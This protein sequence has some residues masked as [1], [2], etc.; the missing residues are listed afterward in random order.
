MVILK[1]IQFYV[2]FGHFKNIQFYVTLYR[3]NLLPLLHIVY[4][5]GYWILDIGLEI[6]IIYY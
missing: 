3:L 2:T 1:N 4:R 5:F 6:H